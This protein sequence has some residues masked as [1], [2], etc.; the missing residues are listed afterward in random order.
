MRARAQV[1]K[2]SANLS[3]SA[4]IAVGDNAPFCACKWADYLP[5]PP[6]TAK[7]GRRQPCAIAVQCTEHQEPVRLGRGTQSEEVRGC[8]TANLSGGLWRVTLE[9]V[10]EGQEREAH[11]GG[12]HE[13][14]HVHAKDGSGAQG[15][16]TESRMRGCGVGGNTSHERGVQRESVVHCATTLGRHASPTPSLL[17]T[18]LLLAQR[19]PVCTPPPHAMVGGSLV[20]VKRPH[21]HLRPLESP[22]FIMRPPHAPKSYLSRQPIHFHQPAAPNDDEHELHRRLRSQKASNRSFFLFSF[23]F[24]F[25]SRHGNGRRRN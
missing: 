6:H 13:N 24:F 15:E 25:P 18:F 9:P 16:K 21:P 22:T 19:A 17:V 5:K 4:R 12:S 20:V 7:P 8:E 10:R 3:R 1:L 11:Q 23:S 2:A 14:C